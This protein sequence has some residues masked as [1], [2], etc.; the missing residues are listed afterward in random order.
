MT[1][2]PAFSN[3]PRANCPPV[4]HGVGGDLALHDVKIKVTNKA[5]TARI[6]CPTVT[7]CA[8]ALQLYRAF[9]RSRRHLKAVLIGSSTFTVTGHRTATVTAKLTAAGRSLLRHR[10]PLVAIARLAIVTPTGRTV[11][12]SLK[13]TLIGKTIGR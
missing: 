7:D 11:K 3:Q 1:F 10:K 4:A 6:R 5:L 2:Q 8:G 13:V 9:S 12:Q